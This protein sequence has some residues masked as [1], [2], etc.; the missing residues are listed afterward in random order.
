MPVGKQL[1]EGGREPWSEREVKALVEFILFHGT[2]DKW[3]ATKNDS[4]WSKAALFVKQRTGACTLRTS[5]FIHVCVVCVHVC[6][7]S[8]VLSPDSACR[9]K[10]IVWLKKKF[11]T[12]TDAEREYFHPQ[13]ASEPMPLTREA[14]VQVN[15]PDSVLDATPS[16]VSAVDRL[17]E[18]ERMHL[19]SQVL[20]RNVQSK[21]RVGVPEDFLEKASCAMYHLHKGGRSNVLYALAHGLGTTQQ[22]LTRFPV[23][24]MP[25][26]LLEYMANFFAANDVG[27][28]GRI[29]VAFTLCHFCCAYM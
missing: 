21:Y 4:F 18:D 17:Q 2:G 6:F 10:V 5:E 25:M 11:R 22:D 29:H 20:A 1:F 16:I 7:D 9:Y 3:P 27:K 24:R 19:I 8:T 28:V 13:S 14:G 12:P 26:G 23:D 15:I